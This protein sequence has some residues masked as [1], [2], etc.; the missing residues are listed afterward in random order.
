M[1]ILVLD[2]INGSPSKAVHNVIIN[3]I[4]FQMAIKSGEWKASDRQADGI[5]QGQETSGH[6]LMLTYFWLQSFRAAHNPRT[7]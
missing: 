3:K 7:H 6:P 4:E 5:F 2:Q 1:V